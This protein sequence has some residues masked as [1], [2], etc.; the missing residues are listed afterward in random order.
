MPEQQFRV[1]AGS[2]TCTAT[3]A[4]NATA[5]AIWVG[6]PLEAR[7][8]RWGDELYFS[9]SVDAPADPGAQAE[10]RVGDVAFWPPGNAIC[11]FWG[12]TP[13]SVGSEPRAASPVSVFAHIADGAAD[14]GATPSGTLVRLEPV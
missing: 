14:L 5:R 12:P 4:S 9:V 8:N 2:V 6:L 1:V 7:A 11:I 13:A 10:V 3:L